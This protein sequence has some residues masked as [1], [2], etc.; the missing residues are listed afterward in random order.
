[1][2]TVICSSRADVKISFN[3]DS[4]VSNY[5]LSH[6]EETNDKLVRKVGLLKEHLLE[7]QMDVVRSFHVN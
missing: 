6:I 7:I 5:T 1:M 3:G 2:I 4:N